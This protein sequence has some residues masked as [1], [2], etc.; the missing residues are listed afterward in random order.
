[1]QID[2]IN[3]FQRKDQEIGEIIDYLENDHL[4]ADN[5]RAKRV[6]LSEDVYF[7]DDHQLWYHL[8]KQGRKGH[9]ERHAPLVLPPPLRYEVLVHAHDDLAGGHLG[10]Y[11]TYE[12]LKDRFYWSGI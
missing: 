7:I 12:K 10:T 5:V 6:L 8:D 4:P 2:Q 1:M 3:A 11:K 9:K